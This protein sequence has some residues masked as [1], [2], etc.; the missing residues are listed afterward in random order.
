MCPAAPPGSGSTA[1]IENSPNTFLSQQCA[2]VRLSAVDTDNSAAS[3]S[4]RYASSKRSRSAPLPRRST[5][6][7]WPALEDDGDPIG[8][9][10]GFS[11]RIWPRSISD[12]TLVGHGTNVIARSRALNTD[13]ARPSSAVRFP[14]S[15]S[16][17]HAR[18]SRGPP[19]ERTVDLASC[20]QR[21]ENIGQQGLQRARA[22]GP[23]GPGKGLPPAKT[24]VSNLSP[25]GCWM[26]SQAEYGSSILLTRSTLAR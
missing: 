26:A 25:L 16:D 9:H 7:N 18:R 21:A 12:P 13:S 14:V 2:V 3:G 19:R 5:S 8:C 11:P 1:Q 20:L 4:A 17:N 6:P 22:G 10:Q 15:S 23:R 24:L